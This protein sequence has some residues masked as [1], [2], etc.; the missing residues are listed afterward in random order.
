MS[1][2]GGPYEVQYR[3]AG[4]W[5]IGHHGADLADPEK[6]ARLLNK[7]RPARVID[8]NTGEVFGCPVCSV[9]GKAHE[10]MDGSCLLM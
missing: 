9:C 2:P 10:G 4:E 3:E 5:R 7:T 1:E 8:K 6:Y